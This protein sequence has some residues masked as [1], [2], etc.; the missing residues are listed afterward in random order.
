MKLT[1]INLFALLDFSIFGFLFWHFAKEMLIVKPQG[2]FVGQVNLYGDLVFHIGLINKIL[3]SKKILPDSP[4]YAGDKPNY[5][6]FADLI[7]ALVSK[8]FGIDFALFLVTFMAG[9]LVIYLSRKFVLTF[10]KNEKIVFITLLLFFLNGGLGFYYFFQDLTISN[11]PLLSFL[12]SMPHEYTDLKDKGY[13]WINNYLAY[14]LPQRGFLFAFPIT[15]TVFLLLYTGLQKSKRSFFIL[16]GLL[17][18]VLP[19]VQAHSLFVIFIVSAYA[20]LATTISSK[21]KRQIIINWLIFGIITLL[22][23]YILFIQIT[24]NTKAL[25]SIRFDPGW[26]SKENIFW[27]WFKNLGIFAPLL[28]VSTIWLFKNNKHLFSLYVPFLLIFILSNIFV[29]QPWEF[30][31]SKLLIYWYFASSIVVAY[32]L[33][34]VLFSE[35]FLKKSVG[36]IIILVAIFA[37]TLDIFRTFTPSTSYQIFSQ[38]DLFLASTIKRQ[39][40][41][42]TIFLTAPVHNHPIPALTGRSTLLGFYGWVWSHGLSYQQRAI[43]IEKI[44]IGDETAVGLI[45]KYKVSYITVGPHEKN[46]FQINQQ[47]LERYRRINLAP[48]W[49]LYDV[50]NLWSNSNR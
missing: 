28:T 11:K 21:F 31:N 25:E 43:D 40:P 16:A 3:V 29:F 39:T 13:W 19:I 37:G 5:P 8:I 30:D 26:T 46:Q 22:I 15:L 42:D 1:R 9:L 18:G 2:W 23:A 14:F 48:G 7:T 35:N 49:V 17:S 20:F 47:F 50:S 6:I 36:I 24:S 27:F 34:N 4:I 10:L 45:K 32:F 12:T 33:N 41:Q 38:P 44:Y